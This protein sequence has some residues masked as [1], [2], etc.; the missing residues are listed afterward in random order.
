MQ[1]P[2]GSSTS[3]SIAKVNSVSVSGDNAQVS[4]DVAW[5]FSDMQ[6]SMPMRIALVRQG[7]ALRRQWKVDLP[8]TN[9]LTAEEARNMM[10]KMFPA[11]VP[12]VR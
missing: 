9:K 3:I 11:S 1:A 2:E 10:Q 4:L 12:V 5:S 6:L 8:A 7:S